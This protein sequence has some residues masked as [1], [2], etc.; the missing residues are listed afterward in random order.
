MISY[1]YVGFMFSPPYHVT[2]L[3]YTNHFLFP[4]RACQPSNLHL[5]IPSVPP[6]YQTLY[7]VLTLILLLWYVQADSTRKQ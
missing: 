7:A 5:A 3:C 1:G 6:S 4:L 2:K